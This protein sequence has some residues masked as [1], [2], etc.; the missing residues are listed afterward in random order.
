MTTTE[1]CTHEH[2]EQISSTATGEMVTE[3]LRCGLVE[4]QPE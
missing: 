4:G 2:V 1:N 3:C